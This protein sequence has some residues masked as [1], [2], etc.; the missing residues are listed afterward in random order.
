M[1][2]GSS[3]ATG[4]SPATVSKAAGANV[5]VSFVAVAGGLFA[6]FL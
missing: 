4:S 5:A 6:M 3:T 1:T 2:S